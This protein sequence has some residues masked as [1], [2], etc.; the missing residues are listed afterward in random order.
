[1][2]WRGN[3]FEHDLTVQTADL[4][5]PSIRQIPQLHSWIENKF[6]LRLLLCILGLFLPPNFTLSF[7]YPGSEGDTVRTQ[8]E[9][10]MKNLTV[11][12]HNGL[13]S[14]LQKGILNKF[15]NAESTPRLE[16]TFSTL[17]SYNPTSVPRLLLMRRVSFTIKTKKNRHLHFFVQNSYS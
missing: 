14:Q 15:Q 1:M 6:M 17:S 16:P 9:D 13:L 7:H 11:F 3:Q 10:I 8:S 2:V 12:I 5:L 4:S